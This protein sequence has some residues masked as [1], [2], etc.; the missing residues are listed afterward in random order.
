MSDEKKIIA[1][2]TWKARINPGEVSPIGPV[3]PG[4]TAK[5]PNKK[6]SP[7][8]AKEISRNT[9]SF[10]QEKMTTPDGSLKTMKAKTH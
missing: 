8:L 5:G 10:S 2:S 4:E 6:Y 9:P 7:S 1:G 3:S